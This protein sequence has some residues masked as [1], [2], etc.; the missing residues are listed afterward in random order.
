MKL[1]RYFYFR[2]KSVPEQAREHLM[3]LLKSTREENSPHRRHN[4]LGEKVA[5]VEGEKGNNRSTGFLSNRAYAFL[6]SS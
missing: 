4:T 2:R 3:E 5:R 6:L 1:N